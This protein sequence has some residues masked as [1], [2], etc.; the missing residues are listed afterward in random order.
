MTSLLLFYGNEIWE[1]NKKN[2]SLIHCV[3]MILRG[4]KECTKLDH[5]RNEN[6]R[7]EL[8]IYSIHDTV[9]KNNLR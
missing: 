6:T 8:Q 7:N 1:A 5:I 3:K 2:S 4:T 9:K